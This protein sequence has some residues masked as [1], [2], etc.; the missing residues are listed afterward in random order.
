MDYYSSVYCGH[1]NG[2]IP[3]KQQLVDEVILMYN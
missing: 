3:Y 1:E 2:I